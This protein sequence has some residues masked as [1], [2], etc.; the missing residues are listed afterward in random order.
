MRAIRRLRDAP[1]AG[2]GTLADRRAGGDRGP[3]P[4]RPGG[5]LAPWL[6]AAALSAFNVAGP[7]AE[8]G[9][10]IEPEVT[11]DA[12]IAA[13]AAAFVCLIALTL[14]AFRTARSFAA[15]HGKLARG[16]T[17]SIGQRLGLDIALLAVAGVGLWQLRH[18]GAP[19]TRSVQGTLGLDP[20]LVATPAIGLLA[21][22]I[23][24]LRI[25]PLLAQLIERATSGRR[26]SCRRWVPASSPGARSATRERPCC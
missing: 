13:A 10:T 23:V 21:G 16:E 11:P 3:L 1:F 14:P 24:A 12:Y 25:V 19:L 22:A 18:Y 6:G 7:L 4:D 26:A 17:A 2:R 5:L 15:T 8:I 9:L 20:L